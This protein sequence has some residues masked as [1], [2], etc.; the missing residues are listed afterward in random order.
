MLTGWPD[1]PSRVQLDEYRLLSEV[2]GVDVRTLPESPAARADAI[3]DWP[4]ADW[5]H[6]PPPEP[7]LRHVAS[8][9]RTRP[10]SPRAGRR[11][12]RRRHPRALRRVG[13]APGRRPACARRARGSWRRCSRSSAAEGPI[14]ATR[15]YTLYNRASGGK[16]LTTTARAPLSIGACTGSRRSARSCFDG[17]V[18]RLP[19]QPEVRVRELGDR[20]LEEVPLDEVAELMRRL[21][22]EDPAAAKRAV[23]STYG[24]VRLTQRAEEYLDTAWNQLRA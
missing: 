9:H 1:P 23:L 7:N 24:L 22:L 15:A 2:A 17:E 14:V 4:V 5:L 21:G 8:R 18:V 13:A 20:V 3:R 19:D 11:R 10:R 12:R 6:T 16:K